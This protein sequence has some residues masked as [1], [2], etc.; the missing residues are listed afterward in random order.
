M[1]L[2][3]CER[4]TRLERRINVIGGEVSGVGQPYRR[5][6]ESCQC[7]YLRTV[8]V[9]PACQVHGK[10]GV[11]SHDE[12]VDEFGRKRRILGQSV[13]GVMHQIIV[14]DQCPLG[15]PFL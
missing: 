11:S 14:P 3:Q 13:E 2:E 15:S 4:D 7:D 12:P 8:Q 9:R 5:F 6:F 10:V 1:L